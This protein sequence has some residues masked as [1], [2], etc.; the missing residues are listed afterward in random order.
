MTE[1]LAQSFQADPLVAFGSLLLCFVL[2]LLAGLLPACAVLYVIYYLLT[3]PMRR[4][5]RSRLFLDLLQ[6]GL[7]DGRSP[8][9]A[10]ITTAASRDR[11][12]GRRFHTLAA[13]LDTGLRLGEA[14]EKVPRLASP[15][16]RAMLQT[17][18]RIGDISKVLPACRQLLKDSVSQ[19]RAAQNYLIILAFGVTPF[20]ILVPLVFRIKVLP[21]YKAVFE[22]MLEGEVLPAF[23]RFVFAEN[24]LFTWIQLGLLAL[25]WLIAAVYLGGPRLGSW[26]GAAVP[27]LPDWL[28]CCLPWR[29]K[30]LQRDFSAMLAVLLDSGV[31]EAEAVRLAGQSTG[32]QVMVRRA[33]VVQ[34][35]LREGVKL[36]D[37]IRTMDSSCELQ[38]R[39][40]NALQRGAGFVR[41]LTGW[42]DALD[43]K[44]FQLEQ[45]AAQVTTT[46]LVLLNG[47]MVACIVIA[48][49]LC[50]IRLINEA[51]LW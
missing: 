32:N 30:R 47:A 27:G 37:A 19:V 9:A 21:A 46:C 24:A 17:G 34:Q 28:I 3:L 35:R 15:Q 41:A 7:K 16:I 50:L 14:L 26:L 44:A 43:A 13:W 18:E 2:Y 25:L 39:L 1:S 10:I 22:G 20:A 42:H 40:S 6:L 33:A 23:T 11:S 29:R 51:I 49:F 45:A 12:L 4:N 36:P 38:W 8:E 48:V 5:E 31:P